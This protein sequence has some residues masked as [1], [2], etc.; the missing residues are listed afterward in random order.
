MRIFSLKKTVF[1]PTFVE[2]SI[3]IALF[4]LIGLAPA[5]ATPKSKKSVSK[6][7]PK[8]SAK[9][10]PDVLVF[11]NGDRITGNLV[12]ADGANIYFATDE[13]GQVTVP[14]A[15]IKSFETSKRFAVL[16]KN[17]TAQRRHSNPSIPVGSLQL[18]GKMLTIADNNT[19]QNVPVSD[20]SYVIDDATY[21][22]NVAHK[23]GLLHGI[24]GSV[25]EGYSQVNSTFSTTT[26]TSA[27]NLTRIVPA[28]PWMKPGRRTLLNFSN[29]YST[30]TQ[31]PNPTAVT[32]ILLGSLEED[33]YLKPRFYVLEQAIYNINSVE[34]LALEQTYGSGFGYTTVKTP[35]QELDLSATVNYT[36]QQFSQPV[37]LAPGQT[38]NATQNLIGATF[39]DNYTYKFPRKIVLTEMSNVTPEFNFPQAYTANVTV[40][41]TMPIFK[42][43]GLSIQAIDNY[44][45]DPPPGFKG[46]STQYTT[47]L[48]YTIP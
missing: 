3:A 12:K 18:N 32:N 4:L 37:T 29:A 35:K 47:G 45:N 20:I 31:S 41:A 2:N 23:Q 27:I 42:N 25:T 36:Q 6:S 39:A 10:Q 9:A 8:A 48:T 13:A 44:L 15:K 33:E 19:S 11:L 5:L 28:V 34:G 22:K 38:P 7:A 40:G 43:F 24:S 30:F 46:N 1:L 14:W 16:T 26:I 21:E 17:K